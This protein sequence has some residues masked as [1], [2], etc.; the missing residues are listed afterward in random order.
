MATHNDHIKWFRD[1]S[2]YID[3]HR[4]KTFVVYI[5]G[6]GLLD[7]NFPN[8]ISDFALLNALG[9]RLVLVHGAKPQIDDQLKAPGAGLKGSG[10]PRITTTDLI[11]PIASIIGA[12]HSGLQAKLSTGILNSPSTSNDIWVASGNYVKAKPLGIID[13]VDYHLTGKAR[14]VNDSLICQ[15]LEGGAIVLV[16]PLG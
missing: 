1:S 16:S 12:I 14:R 10:G 4:G 5:G 2:P 6:D 9:I 3:A 7:A 8:I 13:G 15:H 11:T